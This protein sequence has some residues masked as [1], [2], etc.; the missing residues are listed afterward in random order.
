MPSYI[1]H[2]ISWGCITYSAPGA[3]MVPERIQPGITLNSGIK[4]VFVPF[5]VLNGKAVIK[6]ITKGL[7]K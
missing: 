6:L 5:E 2:Q 7:L 1:I 3:R 4:T